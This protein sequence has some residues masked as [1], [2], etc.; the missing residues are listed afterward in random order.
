M[1]SRSFRKHINRM[2]VH[3]ATLVSLASIFSLSLWS[4]VQL[5]VGSWSTPGGGLWPAVISISGIALASISVIYVVREQESFPAV[6][7]LFD[8][9]SWPQ[10]LKFS[11]ASAAFLVMYPAIGFIGSA[12]LALVS[13]L[14]F[15]SGVRWVPAII[16]AI[17]TVVAVFALFREVLGVRF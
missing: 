14:R 15:V 13:L 3:Y 8:D 6:Q 10:V 17:I 5:G 2:W 12:T 16:T 11:L 9:V 4:G 1:E 7:E